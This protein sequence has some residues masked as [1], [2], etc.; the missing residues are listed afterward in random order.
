MTKKQLMEYLNEELKEFSDDDNLIL[1]DE[2]KWT[3]QLKPKVVCGK[4][5]PYMPYYCVLPPNHSG[6]CYCSCKS[7]DFDPEDD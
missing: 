3:Y 7:I 2:I 1:G 5:V 4:T 6:K